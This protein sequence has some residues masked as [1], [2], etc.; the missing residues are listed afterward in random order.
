[1]CNRILS[2]VRQTHELLCHDNYSI[3]VKYG[4]KQLAKNTPTLFTSRRAKLPGTPHGPQGSGASQAPSVVQKRAAPC[5]VGHS[6]RGSQNRAKGR[7]FFKDQSP[8]KTVNR[9]KIRGKK[10]S[11]DVPD[12]FIRLFIFMNEEEFFLR[13]QCQEQVG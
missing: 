3:N 1:M 4:F 10:G 13:V 11:G 5:T 12:K 9:L 2:S 6:V 8:S 7:F